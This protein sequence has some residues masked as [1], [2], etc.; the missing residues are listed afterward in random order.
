MSRRRLIELLV[1]LGVLLL[2]LAVFLVR[3]TA[4]KTGVPPIPLF[5]RASGTP[6][7]FG[8][9]SY[10]A[11]TATSPDSQ[12]VLVL[13]PVEFEERAD[14]YVVPREGDGYRLVLADS[15]RAQDTPKAV[16]WLDRSHAWVTVG[17][18]YGTVSP[19]GD[20]FSVD[21]ITGQAAS[22]WASPDSGRTQAVGFTPPN[23]V[24]LKAF[25]DN[26]DHPRDS[27][28]TLT[29]ATAAW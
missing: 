9:G 5:Q 22:L 21:L 8:S 6:P 10:A 29:R 25:D 28:V 14:L 26:M 2:L 13:Y 1:A 15:T 16:G 12:R 7:D 19:G 3:P 27:T 23:V 17:P 11:L 24:R 4:R 20:L 18:T